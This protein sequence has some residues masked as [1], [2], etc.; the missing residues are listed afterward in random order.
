[1]LKT[2]SKLDGCNELIYIK[3]SFACT[4]VIYTSLLPKDQVTKVL[5]YQNCHLYNFSLLLKHFYHLINKQTKKQKAQTTPPPEDQIKRQTVCASVKT[6]DSGDHDTH[7]SS[8]G[9][10][11]SQFMAKKADPRA[12]DS[13]ADITG[14]G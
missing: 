9:L 1:M 14:G 5:K 13:L 12:T 4:A 6:V 3:I 11:M 8:K 10:Y 7:R 2:D